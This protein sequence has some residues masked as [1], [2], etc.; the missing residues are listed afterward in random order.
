MKKTELRKIS[1]KQRERNKEWAKIRLERIAE[2]VEKKGY[3][4]CEE[5]GLWGYTYGDTENFKYLDGHHRDGNRRN[6]TKENCLIIHRICHSL[7]HH[8]KGRRFSEEG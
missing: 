2:Q 6:S 1:Q 4:Y 3:A 8:N 7:S 5:C